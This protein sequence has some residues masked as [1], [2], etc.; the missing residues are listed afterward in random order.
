MDNL[1]VYLVLM[2]ERQLY[3]FQLI[4]HGRKMTGK[5]KKFVVVVTIFRYRWTMHNGWKQPGHFPIRM[6][7]ASIVLILS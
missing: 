5:L 2:T 3:H 6:M 4:Y 1:T 7:E